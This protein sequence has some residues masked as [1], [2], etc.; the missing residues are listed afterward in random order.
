MSIDRIRR[1]AGFAAL[2]LSATIVACNKGDSNSASGMFHK[3]APLGS[4]IA[5]ATGDAMPDPCTMLSANEA[6]VYVGVLASPPYRADDSGVPTTSGEACMYRGT[7]GRQISITRLK[8]GGAAGQI[9]SDVPNA[10]GGALDKAGAGNLAA[11][12]HRVMKDV[13]NG[14]WDH[15]TWIPGGSMMVTKGDDAA[16]IDVTAASGKEDDAASIARQVVPRF[17]H[18]LDYDGATAVAS[19]PKPKAHPAQ[20]CDLVPRAAIEAAI[21]ALDGAPTPGDADECD[22]RVASADGPRTYKVSYT[23]QGGQKNYNML[24]HGMS[25]LGSAMGGSIPTGAMDSMKMDPNMSKMIGGLMKM[26]GGGGPGA[27]GAASQVGFRTDTTLKGP[28]DNA[29]LLHGTQLLA[30]KSDVMVAMDL[31]SADYE[32]AKA[33]LAVICSRL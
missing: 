6:E 22:Y 5:S 28:W 30:V 25:T 4:A 20:A 12:T 7:D 21:G 11:A 19:A 33:L 26:A 32:R 15:A 1:L 3:D 27:A 13:P 17:G 16:N 9:L 18:P 2:G 31:Q 8:G 29:S 14:P 10:V 23:W 24:K